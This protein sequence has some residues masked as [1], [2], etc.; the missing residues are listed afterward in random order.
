MKQHFLTLITLLFICL[1]ST[2]CDKSEYISK[3]DLIGIWSAS[4]SDH[5][6]ITTAVSTLTFNKDNTGIYTYENTN[7][8]FEHAEFTWEKTK[9][10]VT[11]KGQLWNYS[12]MFDR[13]WEMTLKIDDGT[14]DSG[15][16][17]YYKM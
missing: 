1:L 10:K 4:Q 13:E 14:L 3:A 6:G 12:I 9:R 7:S 5:Y 15:E 8:S 17:T 11:C 2:S 16:L